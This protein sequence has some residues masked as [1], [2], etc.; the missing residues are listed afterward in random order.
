MKRYI[1][2]ERNEIHVIDLQQTIKLVK[3]AYYIVRDIAKHR[4]TIL[5]VGT[6]KQAQEAIAA[7]ADRCAQPYINQRWLGGLLTNITTIRRRINQLKQYRKMLDNGVFNE[8]AKKEAAR[9]MKLM[10]R[11]KFYF[12]GVESMAGLPSAVFIVDTK[13]EQLAVN[14]ANRLGIPIIGVVDTN[15]DPTQIQYP[16]PA[17]DDAIRAIKLVCSIIANAVIDGQADLTDEA[18]IAAQLQAAEAAA[19]I[20]PPVEPTVLAVVQEDEA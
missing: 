10:A 1:F 15:A 5:F 18:E 3:E 16:I 19:L 13:K 11:L 4:G 14:E 17:N 7:E 8:M 2:T 6:K 9:H 20:S 12:Q